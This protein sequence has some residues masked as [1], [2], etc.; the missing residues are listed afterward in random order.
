MKG[1][2]IIKANYFGSRAVS[3]QGPVTVQA[4]IFTNYGRP[5][6]SRAN[7]TLRLEKT[8]EVVTLGTAKF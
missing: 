4:V 8:K 2:Y 3:L 7:L 5:N 1:Q 6:E